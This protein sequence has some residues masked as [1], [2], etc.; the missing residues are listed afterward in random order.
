MLR[1]LPIYKHKS[2]IINKIK[3]ND[4]LIL[5]GDT[6][7]GKTTQVPQIIH[8]H[9]GRD[10]NFIISHPRRISCIGVAHRVAAEMSVQIPNVVGE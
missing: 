7:C 9:F 1:K 8:N 10:K 2:E 5:S 4:V 6:G 3:K